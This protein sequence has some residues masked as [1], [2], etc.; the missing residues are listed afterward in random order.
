[1]HHKTV[2]P[3][4]G[5]QN[6]QHWIAGLPRATEVSLTRLRLGHAL[7]LDHKIRKY[8]KDVEPECRLC[9]LERETIDH[10]M[11]QCPT[12]DSVRDPVIAIIKTKTT[13]KDESLINIQT[14]I[15]EHIPSI[16]L[17]NKIR[18]EIINKTTKII[19]EIKQ[20]FFP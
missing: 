5:E 20:Y 15:G 19:H 14:I 4:A 13:A 18:L 10:L 6:R 9:G 2:C 1:M 17:N 7:T 11:L 12:L 3:L 16:N 8:Q